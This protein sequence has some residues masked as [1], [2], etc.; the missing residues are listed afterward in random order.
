M[1]K[2]KLIMA[3]SKC[4]V[5]VGKTGQNGAMAESLTDVG[6]I[7]NQS[8]TLEAEDGE[9]LEAIATGGEQVATEQL[10]G[11]FTLTTRVKEP[12]DSLYTLF[13]L[14]EVKTEDLEVKTHVV[15][16]EW[17]VKVTPKNVGAR[18]IK[19]PCCNIKFKPGYSE[20][21]GNYVD[22]TFSILKGEADYWYTRF[23]KA[24]PSV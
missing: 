19:A 22:L 8:T 14:G 9:V 24:A 7:N 16:G 5:E 18:G 11:K 23:K 4:T 13:G 3:W 6:V 21:E 17:S 12:E 20:T 1:S 15:E 10:E 2:K